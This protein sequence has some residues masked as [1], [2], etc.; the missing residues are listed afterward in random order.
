M[1]HV[2]RAY[3]ASEMATMPDRLA[4]AT[5]AGGLGEGKREHRRLQRASSTN[6]PLS[7]P[8]PDLPHTSSASGFD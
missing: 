8:N 7:K 5:Q 4:A 6:A 3:L 1:A 2:S